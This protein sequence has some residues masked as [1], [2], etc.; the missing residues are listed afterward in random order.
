MVEAGI[1]GK[2]SGNFGNEI[3]VQDCNHCLRCD[4]IWLYD[5]NLRLVE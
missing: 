2:K 1:L 4:T 5:I 3:M